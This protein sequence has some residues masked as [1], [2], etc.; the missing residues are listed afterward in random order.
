MEEDRIGGD[1]VTC[2][3]ATTECD[4]AE[5]LLEEAKND[6]KDEADNGS[7]ARD[8]PS[9]AGEDATDERWVGSHV[10]ECAD[11]GLLVDDEHR[12]GTYGIKRGDEQDK[13]D[14]KEG[15]PLLNLHNAVGI[16]LLLVL[17]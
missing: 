8:E 13:E 11:L 14:E 17:G 4:K 1:D 16:G 9:F 5:V 12:E 2:G 3:V 7:D 15:E 6:A 10:A